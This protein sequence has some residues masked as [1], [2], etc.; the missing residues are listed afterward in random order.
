[1]A[2]SPITR[3]TRKS[4]YKYNRKR[5]LC[6]GKK[7]KSPNKCTKIKHCKVASGNKRTFCR[8]QKSLRYSKR[9][10]KKSKK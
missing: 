5:S 3:K 6:R 7:T 2:L 9:M 8:K 10:Q 4:F 1:M